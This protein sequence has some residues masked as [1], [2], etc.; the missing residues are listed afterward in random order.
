MKRGVSWSPREFLKIFGDLDT[1]K[2]LYIG[3]PNSIFEESVRD[4]SLEGM[5]FEGVVCKGKWKSPGLP[6]MFKIKNRA[7]V[8][9]LK[10]TCDTEEEFEK[11][12]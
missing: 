10:E 6:L 1:A 5:T 12:L 8:E 7:W 9:R 3:N 4:G 2:L 11:R